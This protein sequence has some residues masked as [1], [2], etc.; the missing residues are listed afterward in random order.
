MGQ[1]VQNDKGE[2]LEL[3]GNQ[4]VPVPKG[5][6]PAPPASR[7]SLLQ[8]G[9]RFDQFGE[10]MAVA[11]GD[12]FATMGRNVRDVYAML[13]GDTAARN[14]IVDERAEADKIRARLHEDAPVASVVGSM[15]PTAPLML[16]SGGAAAPGLMGGL[17]VAG[18][19]AAQSAALGAL[20]SESGNYLQDAAIGG[21]L[22]LGTSAA[23]QIVSRVRAGQAAMR[24]AAAAPG[25]ALGAASVGLNDAERETLAGA[26]RAG[27]Q[28]LP[29]QETG[30]LTF[31]KI[32][33]GMAANPFMSKFFDDIEQGNRAQLNR[34]AARAMG[35]DADNVGPAVRMAA[36]HQI[37]QQFDEVG[38]RLGR[39]DIDPLI[40]EVEKMAQREALEG[41][42]RMQ[43]RTILHNLQGGQKE[44][45]AAVGA[46]E[47]RFITGESM[48]KMRSTMSA[49]MRDAFGQGNSEL[50][51]LYGDVLKVYDKAIEDA[52]TQMA[53]KGG[54]GAR[55]A[56]E[57]VAL[58]SQ[59]RDQWNVWRALDRG[60]ATPDGH[61]N[62]AAAAR[63]I[64][65]GDK[66]GYIG[67]T[68]E[69]GEQLLRRGTGSIGENPTGDLYDALRFYT[70]KIGKPAAP[71]TGGTVGAFNQWMNS[72]GT[73]P[74]IAKGG[75]GM[76]ASPLMRQYQNQSPLAA[77]AMFFTSQA[78]RG[79]PTGG[80]GFDLAQQAA[81]MGQAAAGGGFSGLG[82]L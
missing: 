82:G 11:A 23:A 22:S 35:V 3:V 42:P 60:G 64:G 72:G 32:E 67:R 50:G 76:L 74:A 59:A 20:G 80:T 7:E 21:G 31:R 25:G 8:P 2:V 30:N 79:Q 33:A 52:A 65:S 47:G 5:A 58:Y 34:L 62:V 75:L 10:A 54:A 57:T 24:E 16:L 29:G 63:N 41:A 43:I 28:L 56:D 73:V 69:T 6:P 15:L 9:S 40:G 61:V 12:Q 27:L 1:R 78:L 66:S 26:R 19:Q 14:S 68:G 37:G 13:R 51:E 77:Q 38:R 4:W 17:R 46:D 44:R 45:I 36:E 70:S 18:S 48:M 49:K 71:N 53:R 55:A 39:V 81:R